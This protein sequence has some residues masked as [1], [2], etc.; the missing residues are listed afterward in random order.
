[1]IYYFKTYIRSD[2]WKLITYLH[3]NDSS[4]GIHLGTSRNNIFLKP[5]Y[6]CLHQPYLNHFPF[7]G[8]PARLTRKGMWKT[9]WQWF[10]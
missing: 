2:E 6:Y 10:G 8:I 4:T 5:K 9:F 7:I 1:M 3:N